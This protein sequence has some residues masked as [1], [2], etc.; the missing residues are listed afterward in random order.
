MLI[1]TGENGKS[2]LD[3]A[4]ENGD[5]NIIEFLKANGAK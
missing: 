3:F 1:L 2:A 5:S 4:M